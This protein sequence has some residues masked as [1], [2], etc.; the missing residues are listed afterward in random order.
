[1]VLI[2]SIAILVTGAVF[3]SGNFVIRY[4]VIEI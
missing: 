4:N 2:L 3:G 1:M